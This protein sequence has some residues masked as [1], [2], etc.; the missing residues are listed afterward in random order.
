MKLVIDF[1]LTTTS[2]E[3]DWFLRSQA[4]SKE[5]NKDYAQVGNKAG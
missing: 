1:P 5:E 2:L 3:H 4:A